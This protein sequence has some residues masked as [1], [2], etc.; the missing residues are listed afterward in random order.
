MTVLCSGSYPYHSNSS[1]CLAAIHAGIIASETGGSVLFDRFWPETWANDSTQTVFPRGANE[2][3]FSNGVHTLPVPDAWNPVPAP[4]LYFSWTVRSRGVQAAQRQFAP[5]SPRAGHLHVSIRR[6]DS[7][8]HT[9]Y[10]HLILGGLSNDGYLN[11]AWLHSADILNLPPFHSA[12]VNGRWWRLD[13]APFS[14]RAFMGGH[15]MEDGDWNTFDSFAPLTDFP[16]VR[17]SGGRLLV[18]GGQTGHACGNRELGRCANDIWTLTLTEDAEAEAG[19]RLSWSEQPALMPFSARC[20]FSLIHDRRLLTSSQLRLIGVIGGQLSYDSDNCSLPILTTAEAWYASTTD[21]SSW[22]RGRDA[23]FGARS[24]MALDDSFVTDDSRELRFQ[25]TASAMPVLFGLSYDKSVSLAGGVRY[26]E[27][28]LDAELQTSRMTRALLFADVWSCTLST[29][30]YDAA[31]PDCDWRHTAPVA[32]S[33]RPGPYLTTGSLPVPVVHA[34]D[35]GFPFGHYVWNARFGGVTSNA[36]IAAW[37]AAVAAQT[38]YSANSSALPVV[39]LIQ[40]P[41]AALADTLSYSTAETRRGLPW[42]FVLELNAS[43]DESFSQGSA[44][45]LTHTLQAAKSRL[46]TLY[47]TFHTQERQM[48]ETPEDSSVHQFQPRSSL[49]TARGRF[50]FSLRRRDHGLLFTEDALIVSGGSSG[51]Q[52][53]NDWIRY[54]SQPCFSPDDPSYGSLLGRGFLKADGQ[55]AGLGTHN[56]PITEYYLLRNRTYFSGYV[57]SRVPQYMPGAT[58]YWQCAAGFTFEPPLQAAVALLTCLSNGLWLDA[59]LAAA[60]TCV[61]RAPC[62]YPLVSI[63]QGDCGAPAAVVSAI[64]VRLFPSLSSPSVQPSNWLNSEVTD[65]PVSPSAIRQRLLLIV[66]SWFSPP[67]VVTVGGAPCLDPRISS[68]RRYC[69]NASQPA[70]CLQFGS[71]ISCSMPNGGLTPNSAVLLTAGSGMQRID[72]YQY[73]SVRFLAGDLNGVSAVSG[74]S[75]VSQPL[76]ISAAWPSV[77]WLDSAECT[78]LNATAGRAA[79]VT[80]LECPNSEAFSVSVRLSNVDL[81]LYYGQQ[82]R[83]PVLGFVVAGKWQSWSCGTWRICGER[84]A[85][86]PQLPDLLCEEELVCAECTVQ[87]QLGQGWA[88][89]VDTALDA[90]SSNYPQL[91]D[92]WGLSTVSFAGCRAGSYAARNASTGS[93]RCQLCPAGQSTY[94]LDGQQRCVDCAPGTYSSYDGV[95]HCFACEAGSY[96]PLAG[97][98]N[99][100]PCARNREQGQSRCSYCDSNQYLRWPASEER[101]TC[102]LCPAGGAVCAA[103]VLRDDN[104]TAEAAMGSEVTLMAQP[105]AY[106]VIDSSSGLVSALRCPLSACVDASRC[107]GADGVL[108]S[109]ISVQRIPVTQVPVLNC[110]GDNRRPALDSGGGLNVLCAACL[111]GYTD[112][113]GH[114]VACSGTRW[115]RLWLVL[116]AALMLTLLLHRLSS[117]WS[118]SASLPMFFYFIQMSALFLSS[119]TLPAL[120]SFVNIDLLGD[121]GPAQGDA[122][123]ALA[124]CTTPL[125]DYGKVLLRLLSPLIAV[126]CL[127]LLFV[128][129]L[130]LRLGRDHFAAAADA[131]GGDA[132]RLAGALQRFRPAWEGALPV[133]DRAEPL[134]PCSQ[135]DSSDRKQ[136]ETEPSPLQPVPVVPGSLESMLT[137]YRLTLLRLALFSFNS[138]TVTCLAFFHAHRI[139][140]VGTRLWAFPRIDVDDDRYLL[141]RPFVL[142]CLVSVGL[143]GPAALLL[144]LRRVRQRAALL[145]PELDGLDARAA[146]ASSGVGAALM[147]VYSDGYW[148]LSVVVLARRLLLIAIFTF[149]PVEGVFFALSAVNVGVLGLH[150]QLQPYRQQ[151]DNRVETVALTALVA[152]TMLLSAQPLPELRPDWLTACLWLTVL[153]PLLLMLGKFS[154]QAGRKLWLHGLALWDRVV[155][156]PRGSGES[157][158]LLDIGG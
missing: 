146:A 114:C 57:T 2:S 40:Q 46:Q 105:A 44:V 101:P 132:G 131:R 4:R 35:V 53:T 90:Y 73:G 75:G 118:S 62:P 64:R 125:S 141:F 148:F 111:N 56:T 6:L 119:E 19:V 74:V 24:S 20:G 150:L 68:L 37:N 129:Q 107:L 144:Y 134:L 78:K 21:L 49:S 1:I 127:A 72:S 43:E 39:G 110:C 155:S 99:C 152:Q 48:V 106:L 61:Q 29:P 142:L 115:G 59:S 156:L 112:V 108:D 38:S 22:R 31:P 34:A 87:P 10:L 36:A 158:Q 45:V 79:N 100:R 9:H 69:V 117:S 70:S 83:L 7:S 33:S 92:A 8:N 96:Q 42:Q 52:F 95:E 16:L 82:W 76:T 58:L 81:H 136:E 32:N 15:Y 98:T 154:L 97:Q 86:A 77:A 89:T 66:G 123:A 18:V 65:V 26:L 147:A 41:Q 54:E 133:R 63:A 5:Y 145:T 139:G 137:A 122:S 93:T 14:P 94:G 121:A 84:F 88:V 151:L 157:V 3:S 102:E 104:A 140:E 80:L 143:G 28:E 23:P 103:D 50:D 91:G 149:V 11:D 12:S 85:C 135:D 67:V 153:L 126:A 60:R 51:R 27:H 130:L 55:G 124:W 120:A 116:L 71:V 30:E 13:D 25:R 17:S 138:I 113:R 128:T 109:G 47:T